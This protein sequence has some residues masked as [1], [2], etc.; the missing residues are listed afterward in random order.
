MVNVA[1]EKNKR[2]SLLARFNKGYFTDVVYQNQFQ[3]LFAIDN[4]LDSVSDEVELK[5]A[6][7]YFHNA[8]VDGGT[9]I[10][11]VVNYDLLV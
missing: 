3:N 2:L 11:E 8:M 10:L 4:F 7:K 1:L 5:F 9:F 6:F